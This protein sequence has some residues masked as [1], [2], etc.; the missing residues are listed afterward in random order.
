ML[1]PR[2]QFGNVGLGTTIQS[3]RWRTIGIVEQR[4][5]TSGFRVKRFN[6]Q[7][8]RV[9]VNQSHFRRVRG[10]KSNVLIRD[11]E[12][13]LIGKKRVLGVIRPEIAGALKRASLE[14]Q[15]AAAEFFSQQEIVERALVAWLRENGGLNS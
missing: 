10:L 12:Q 13:E 5:G 9:E 1:H 7:K 6:A 2:K 14:R 4:A 8:V 3:H 11:E 15:L